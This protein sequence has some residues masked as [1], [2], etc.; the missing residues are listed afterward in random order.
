[1]LPTAKKN[2]H[3][4][5]LGTGI[6]GLSLAEILSRNGWRI[7]LVDA[8]PDLGG[9]ASRC[10]QNW[11]HTGWL[12]A[13]LPATSAMRACASSLRLLET[14]YGHVLPDDVVNLRAD[15]AGIRYV[16]S[17]VGWFSPESMHYVFAIST[18]D[19]STLKAAGW[20]HYLQHVILR[21]LR[22]LGYP[23]KES[24]DLP[25]GLLDLMA[26]WEGIPDARKCY[27]VVPSTDARVDTKRVLSTLMR[28]L[29]RDTQVI[30][31]V[32]AE[33]VQSGG[34][35][36]VR[37]DGELHTPDLCVLAAGRGLAGLLTQL[38]ANKVAGD[39]TS[40]S[41]PI[42][43]L[44][45]ALDLP[46]FIRFT[47]TLPETIN[48][49]K[50]AVAGGEVSTIGS[51]DFFPADRRPD[52][53]PFVDKVC[54]RLA[55]DRSEVV[56]SYY[57]TKTELTGKLARRYNHA[58]GAV[59]DNTYF[60]IAGKFSQFPLLV[61]EFATEL[62]LRLDVTNEARG[63]LHVEVADTAPERLARAAELESTPPSRV[64][65]A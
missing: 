50:Y 36:S 47:P 53:S 27:R 63:E 2:G 44:R 11:L 18:Y 6:A 37:I 29:G 40:V 30:R 7:T 17:N 51:Y 62:G 21:R 28:M 55:I 31:G 61:Y 38:G 4:F 22:A 39:L 42:V 60:A 58:L 1:M 12:Y 24:T 65:A 57:G 59:N 16:P 56:G 14:A 41:S 26:H 35:T 45:R 33:L 32:S 19:L 46:N 48:H 25:R 49:V 15:D 8:S 43:V 20:S 5:V 10:T 3:A 34:K 23:T 64:A 52:I 9:D 54:G 13:G